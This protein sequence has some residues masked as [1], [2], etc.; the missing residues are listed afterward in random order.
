MLKLSLNIWHYDT[1]HTF[2]VS[3]Q[4]F[5]FFHINSEDSYESCGPRRGIE[6]VAQLL[7]VRYERNATDNEIVAEK[8][9]RNI[10]QA[11]NYVDPDPASQLVAKYKGSREISDVRILLRTAFFSISKFIILANFY[12]MFTSSMIH[13]KLKFVFVPYWLHLFLVG[14]SPR[15]AHKNHSEDT[16]HI[17]L[18]HI[19]NLTV[20]QIL[21]QFKLLCINKD[22]EFYLQIIKWLSKTIEDGDSSNLPSFV[23]NVF[24]LILVALGCSLWNEW[25]LKK[26]CIEI[27]C[28]TYWKVFFFY[29]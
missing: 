11:V 2:L 16:F 27:E 17:I 7:I 1:E 5:C 13:E 22:C 26:L 25:F 23:S 15:T 14:T 20:L 10:F 8:Q 4:K 18:A 12:A 21:F 29:P 24:K 9:Q 6:D 19:C 28:H 3:I